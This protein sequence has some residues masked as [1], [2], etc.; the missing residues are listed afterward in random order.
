ME[1]VM[2]CLHTKPTNVHA[3]TRLTLIALV[4]VGLIPLS[5]HAVGIS[6]YRIY[7]DDDRRSTAFTVTNRD[8]EP[9]DCTLKLTHYNFD[10]DSLLLQVNE[11]EIPPNSA[12]DWI[13]F[14]PLQFKVAP[15]HAQTI[16]FTLRRKANAESAEYRSYLVIDCLTEKQLD[17]DGNENPLISIEPK[18]QHNVPIIVRN[19]TLEA[20]ASI[21]NIRLEDAT[22]AFTIQRTGTRSIHGDVQLINKQTNEVISYQTAFSIYPEAQRYHFKL[23]HNGIAPKDIKIRF[24]EN[25][26]YGGNIVLETDVLE[27]DALAK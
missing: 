13:R 16:R 10:A 24:A 21:E 25:P 23:A 14:S 3:L 18:L 17:A 1:N 19:G 9:Q 22:V 4:M 12:R 20:S 8:V 26:S 5:A 15:A 11:G 7:L 6:A 27:P 2:P